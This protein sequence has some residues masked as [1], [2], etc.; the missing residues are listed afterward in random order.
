M[1]HSEDAQKYR[2]CYQAI[3]DGERKSE[4]VVRVYDR[5]KADYYWMR[6]LLI[7]QEDIPGQH[8][9]AIGFSVNINEEVS[10]AEYH[11]KL[12]HELQV[13]NDRF[14][15]LLKNTECGIAIYRRT[16][17][18][19]FEV[20]YL[21]DRFCEMCGASREELFEQCAGG[22][23][24]CVA[25]EWKA[26]VI[27]AFRHV[28]KT[29]QPVEVT[30]RTINHREV[31][32]W[33]ALRMKAVQV[34]QDTIDVYATYFDVTEGI[35]NRKALEQSREV[36]ENAC[37][38][39][40]MWTFTYDYKKEIAY[41]SLNLQEDYGIPARLIGFPES[42]FDYEF[43]LPECK[44]LYCSSF[45]K[46]KTENR[47]DDFEIQAKL[48]DGYI[49]W[50]RFR[51]A[52]LS[53]KDNMAVCSA[54]IID[55][56]K[57][58]ESRIILEREKLAS[59]G[60]YL[61][62]YAITNIN[63]N[64]ITEYHLAEDYF[65]LDEKILD[66]EEK[67]I[68]NFFLYPTDKKLF[69][70]CHQK[71]YLMECFKRGDTTLEHEYRIKIP[72]RH[73]IWVKNT[74][75]L[76]ADPKTQDVYLYEYCYDINENKT[77]EEVTDAAIKYSYD[78]LGKLDLNNDQLTLARSSRQ[79]EMD[80]ENSR[81]KTVEYSTATEKYADE[82]VLEEDRELFL[83]E[84]SLTNL[85][86]K[87]QSAD[88]YEFT[89]RIRKPDG[90][91]RAMKSQ[92]FLYD[93]Q[94]GIC[95]LT[96][97][98]V[99]SVVEEE[100]KQQKKLQQIADEAEAANLAKSQFLSRMSHE[101]RTPMNAIIGM[102]SI[103]EENKSDFQQVFDCL[104]KIDTSS[105]YLLTLINDI[106]EMSRIESGRLEIACSDFN[107]RILME[108][109]RTIIEP[110]AAKAHIRYQYIE[111]PS[112]D[113]IYVGDEMRIQQILINVLTN[114][115]KFTK[116]SGRVRF[117]VSK[118]EETKENAKFRFVI[119]DTGIGI[120][121][122]FMKRMF[123]PFSQEDSSNTSRYAGSGLGLSISRNLVE[124]M[125][126]TIH[127][128]SY[129]DIGTTFTIEIPLKRV[130]AA[131]SGSKI[132]VKEEP[133]FDLKD[134]RILMAEDHP[135]NVMVAK[136][137]LER[138]GMIVTV[139]GNG[140]EAVDLFQESEKDFYDAVLMDIRMPVM[141][142]LDATRIIRASKRADAGTVP[143]I[144][145]TANALEEDR[146]KTKEAGM[147]AHLAKPFEPNQLYETLAYQI[148]EARKK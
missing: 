92:I 131:V 126:G 100:E 36:I 82:V 102:I 128:E 56:E 81:I 127:A 7:R 73:I 113:S 142:G 61:L 143:I 31:E 110:L 9:K 123:E 141:D 41:T 129:E 121:P 62:G 17:E 4:C 55:T 65:Q 120:S 3:L 104:Q 90:S 24:S 72:D 115:V 39:A 11:K 60:N 15:N 19:P 119:A 105:H 26:D 76:L 74:M 96:R 38:F 106:L 97:T 13:A 144:A 48:K 98:D 58:M 25:D 135:L 37:E 147:N 112:A 33:T 42:I 64:E 1:V 111:E 49:H 122:E 133:K 35:R 146:K 28:C 79:D 54:Q 52:R 136:K 137:L 57:A 51:C 27:E 69:K 107:F 83:K 148:K 118:I 130:H 44:E 16:K 12:Q 77:L 91:V 71:E 95:L 23:V 70:E 2:D 43:I 47:I 124:A 84:A 21:N 85:R 18:V 103:A 45:E 109:V 75:N 34:D 116:S 66:R 63:K 145:M 8:R 10:R 87:L 53:G 125:G 134:C 88:S 94:T 22:Y 140:Q 5:I 46:L 139:A 99:T 20:R 68:E 29:M 67:H 40:G 80:I 78:G 114:A 132:T 117:T 50:L 108:N 14:E 59:G 32:L 30:Y 138:R 86:L 6:V 101:I 93:R 89:T